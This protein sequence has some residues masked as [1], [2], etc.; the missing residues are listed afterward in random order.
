MTIGCGRHAKLLEL[1]HWS[2][3]EGTISVTCLSV[4]VY[5]VVW[6]QAVEADA[7][8]IIKPIRQ[9][10]RSKAYSHVP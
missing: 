4:A 7:C 5:N 10:M 3:S 9:V 6:K 8:R 2:C 1:G